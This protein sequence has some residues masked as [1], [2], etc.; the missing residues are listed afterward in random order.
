MND[1][2]AGYKGS[3]RAVD[4]GASSWGSHTPLKFEEI[5]RA[6][7]HFIQRVLYA[8]SEVCALYKHRSMKIL[9]WT[10][11]AWTHFAWSMYRGTCT[12]NAKR[13]MRQ[14]FHENP[15]TWPINAK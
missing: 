5:K 3:N 2:I 9:T 15:G 1:R 7:P 12:V 4:N 10:C 6:N 14:C 11:F 13:K 8:Q